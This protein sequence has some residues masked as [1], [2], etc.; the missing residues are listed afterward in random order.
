MDDKSTLQSVIKKAEEQALHELFANIPC[1]WAQGSAKHHHL[2]PIWSHKKTAKISW[3]PWF[4][5]LNLFFL[6]CSDKDL[7]YISPKIQLVNTPQL[8]E[9]TN[10]CPHYSKGWP[11]SQANQHTSMHLT[12]TISCRICYHHIVH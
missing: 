10:S 6:G 2:R 9:L 5:G 1:I 4:S 3:L 11:S 12:T 7:L 8:D